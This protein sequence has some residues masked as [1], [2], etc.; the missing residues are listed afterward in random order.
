MKRF[1]IAL[2]LVLTVPVIAEASHRGRPV[3]S[4]VAAVFNRARDGACRIRDAR[5]VRRALGRGSCGSG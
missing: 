5:P 3:R 4:F 1:C 2:A